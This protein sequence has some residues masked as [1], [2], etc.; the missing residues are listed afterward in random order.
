MAST[1]KSSLRRLQHLRGLFLNPTRALSAD[2]ANQ[3]LSIGSTSI[4][5]LPL[6]PESLEKVPIGVR[7]DLNRQDIL[8][9]LQW[10]MQKDLLGQDIFLLGPPGTLRRNI[11]LTYLHLTNREVE[12]VSLHRDTSGESDFKQRREIRKTPI[13]RVEWID[14]PA[15]S[16]ALHGRVLVIEG[17]E[18]AER[19][20]LPVLNNLL[21]NRE[22]TLEDGR[23]LIH[24]Q[25]YDHLRQKHSE[26]QLLKW[27][28]VRVSERFRVIA[29]GV[30]IPPYTGNPL[31]PPFRS[32]FQVRYID[33]YDSP[34]TNQLSVNN[35]SRDLPQIVGDRL[36]NIEKV[37][38]TLDYM[39]RT[40]E[41]LQSLPRC[42]QTSLPQ[43]KA[44]I[45]S[46]PNESMIRIFNRFYPYVNLGS[47]SDDN[48]VALNKLLAKFSVD[49]KLGTSAPPYSLTSVSKLNEP[50]R[51]SI[52][53]SSSNTNKTI[54]ELT[55]IAVPCGS[56]VVGDLGSD[57][58]FVL[59]DRVA[60]FTVDMI[61]AHSLGDFA[62]IGGKSS[63]KSTLIRH[64]ANLLGYTALRDG[65]GVEVVHLYKDMTAR[66][67]LQ[68]RG[69]DND[70]NT[71]WE[72]AP[73]VL[74]AL[75]GR[76][77]VL[78]GIE[79]VAAG[80]LTTLQRLIQD[81]EV[82][83]PDGTFLTSQFD[84]LKASSGLTTEELNR[85]GVFPIHPSFRVIGTATLPKHVQGQV[86]PEQMKWFSEEL[87]AMFQFLYLAPPSKE[88]EAAIVKA[89]T[90]CPDRELSKILKFSSNFGKLNEEVSLLSKSTSFSTSNRI[91]HHPNED[92]YR[93]I[94]RV[95]LSNFMP[96][97]ARYSL[98]T[99]LESS[100]IKPLEGKLPSIEIKPPTDGSN[101]LVIGD[102]QAQILQIPDSSR[103][104]IP[105]IDDFFE[106]DLHKR[107]LRD[108]L[109][110]YNLGEHLLL[111]GNQ[112]VG[113]NK[114]TDK[115]LEL[116]QRPREYIQLHRDTTVQSI[117]TQPSVENGVILWKD[118][119]LLKAVKLGHTLVIDEAD[120]APVY[121]VS[122]LKSLAESGELTLPDGRRI[123]P[124][125]HPRSVTTPSG[126]GTDIF[127][128]PDFRMIVLAN[129]PGSGF[130]GNDFFQAIGDVFSCHP[131][132]NPDLQ[133][134]LAVV[135]A[136]APDVPQDI[137][138]ALVAAFQ[139]LRAV[140]DEGSIS[141]PYSLRELLHIARHMQKFPNDSIESVIRNVFD[142]DLHRNEITEILIPTLIRHGL[143]ISS[144]FS[145][146]SILEK[147]GEKKRLELKMETN[148]SHSD[149][150]GP[151][152]GKEDPEN[153]PHVGGNQWAGGTGGRDTAG[154]GGV[155]GPYRLDKGHNVHRVS[156]EVKNAVPE[157]I[158]EAARQMG[159]EALLKRLKEI[160]MSEH[161]SD[162]YNNIRTN[163]APLVRQLNVI[164]SS[165]QSKTKERV[166][167]KNQN[168]GDLDETKLVEG[169][170]GEHS[171]YKRRGEEDPDPHA[172]WLKPKRLKFVFDVSA[173]MYSF[174]GADGRLT[175]SLEAALLVM[176]GL[177]SL[178]HKFVYDIVGHSGDSAC[179][180]FVKAGAPPTNEKER[181][182]GK[183]LFRSSINV[184]QQ[185]VAHSQFCFSGDT[186]IQATRT[187][188][189]DVAKDDA[190]DYHVIILSDAN[191]Q[192]Y[193]IRPEEVKKALTFNPKVNA[194]MIFIGALGSE[195]EMLKKSLPPF[196]A[197]I[198]RQSKDIPNI[199][200]QIFASVL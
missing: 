26:E 43:I 110:D 124:L 6:S 40:E 89:L 186:T 120:K 148:K 66:D 128:H 173:S 170:T 101:V 157:E 192:R 74:A 51:A 4:D 146:S 116:L 179:I 77:A 108:M 72:N 46:F 86:K 32:R 165:L 17:I 100:G 174:N 191:L 87:S 185:M 167:L 125:P 38:R 122:I 91:A 29:L 73:L 35:T 121:V 133:S 10:I 136:V 113:K 150:K 30:P 41:N 142:F 156:D 104:L 199:M 118:S 12:Y 88:E 83:L 28:L 94:N 153:K 188:I 44:S 61:Q 36:N 81:R 23:H 57:H 137:L 96:Q 47:L 15:V 161:E 130:L 139:E 59:T 39:K 140:F 119:P 99:L 1:A 71:I 134:E 2:A 63:G 20:V 200:R 70:G 65:S 97:I 147:Q 138:K 168:E 98:D 48:K 182:K 69:T 194:V 53:L 33:S 155:A 54:S 9:H 106:N 95:F 103:A 190:D 56:G 178:E 34:F 145:L 189:E 172:N 175:R 79:N 90:N 18:K 19:N 132:D 169:M 152:H 93:D 163:I 164:L 181:L 198:A 111:I 159:R 27:N 195:A 45:E 31:D 184:L 55:E 196:R 13:D 78:E 176:E 105:K 107:L 50:F 166:W 16:A 82:T 58:K 67:L 64:F 158:K 171:V 14:G 162:V 7:C 109:M 80:T 123:R 24:P 3:T 193:G 42:S 102:I 62:V 143:P 180:P 131:V 160:E 115:F 76:L 187:A 52:T 117:I 183:F 144:D 114:I 197:F 11:A 84:K 49:T 68:R 151:K 37:V 22:I 21:E 5:V 85:R 141:Y 149:L 25:R 112:G 177:Q 92:L 75:S 129:R 154:L 126:D 135:S 127:V 8:E 60:Q